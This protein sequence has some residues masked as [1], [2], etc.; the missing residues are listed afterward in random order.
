MQV[1]VDT[2]LQFKEIV[3]DK[4]AFKLAYAHRNDPEL[5]FV[6]QVTFGAYWEGEPLHW[7]NHA[8]VN[9]RDEA[10]KMLSELKGHDQVS[11]RIVHEQV[12][13]QRDC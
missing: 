7:V 4:N 13:A 3:M 5:Q 10:L 6:I 2:A 1:V 11:Y 12:I 8:R 9:D